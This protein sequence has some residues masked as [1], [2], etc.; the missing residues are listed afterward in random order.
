MNEEKDAE[1]NHNESAPPIQRLSERSKAA[2]TPA[3]GAPT[4]TK[5]PPTCKFYL[6]KRG[7]A[8]GAECKFSHKVQSE[9]TRN[10][11][12]KNRSG[13]GSRLPVCRHFTSS[14]SSGCKYGDKCRY[15]HPT[16][17]R[18]VREDDKLSDSV[19]NVDLRSDENEEEQMSVS[20]EKTVLLDLTSFPGL[21][22]NSELY[23]N[24]PY[25]LI[26]HSI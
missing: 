17:Q 16:Q 8:Y 4:K 7:C 3:T 21:T 11:P 1:N 23:C 20:N 10:D 22:S 19:Q 5:T 9:P 14:S 12:V 13:R 25:P 15:R 26:E 6:T 24:T 2:N 18:G